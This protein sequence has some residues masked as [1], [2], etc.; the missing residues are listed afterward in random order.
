MVLREMLSSWGV[1]V[2][3]AETGKDALAELG[4][5]F[6]R[7][8]LLDV[9]MPGMDG[10]QVA[11][12]IRNDARLR[13][14]HVVILTSAGRRGDAARCRELGVD[15][16]LLKPVK[17]S[18]LL[19]AITD[20][21]RVAP[22][23]EE[24]PPLIT[25][26]TIEEKQR[27]LRILLAED[28]AINQRLATVML[29]R[30]GHAVRAVDSGMKVLSALAEEHFDLVLMDVQMPEMDGFQATRA[31][32]ERPE[33]TSLPVVAMTAHAMKGDRERCLRAGMDD[34][35]PKPIERDELFRIL[36]DWADGQGNRGKEESTDE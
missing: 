13:E 29:Q 33:W 2:A 27:R 26:H 20:I 23:V 7:L 35:L 8:V 36:E 5:R 19:D 28:N 14:T 12:R 24:Q 34:Y 32:R 21:L 30:A 9:L 4:R 10:F 16:Y 11:E 3:E 17:Q 1:A 6:Y 25:R 31:I 15:A 18:Q 22:D